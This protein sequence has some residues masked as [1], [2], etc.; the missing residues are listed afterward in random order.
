MLGRR[1]FGQVLGIPPL[2]RLSEL[3]A[4]NAAVNSHTMPAVPRRCRGKENELR[5]CDDVGAVFNYIVYF[6]GGNPHTPA[7]WAQYFPNGI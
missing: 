3:A 2:L 4:D 6:L 1:G 5:P 7:K